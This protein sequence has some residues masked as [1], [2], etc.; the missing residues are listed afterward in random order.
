MPEY[1]S[2]SC[3]RW[4][5]EKQGQFVFARNQHDNIVAQQKIHI[6]LKETIVLGKSGLQLKPLHVRLLHK[7]NAPGDQPREGGAIEL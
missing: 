7:K 6:R 5:H 1:E 4:Y 3:A 2:E